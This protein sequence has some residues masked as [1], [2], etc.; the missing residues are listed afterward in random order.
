MKTEMNVHNS[1]HY[2]EAEP[3]SWK[4]WKK[5]RYIVVLLAFLGYFSSYS[6]RV[7][8]SVAI[9]AMTDEDNVSIYSK[10]DRYFDWHPNERGLIFSSFYWAYILTQFLGGILAKKYGGNL[11][12]FSVNALD[13]APDY[14]SVIL[15]FS[16]TFSC[17]TGVISP[18]ITGNLIQN[19]PSDGW[20]IIFY[21][22]GGMYVAGCVIYWFWSSGE[23]QSWSQTEKSTPDDERN[24]V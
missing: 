2:E 1:S 6:L 13:I 3:L 23:L 24:G 11:Y 14:A 10:T 5:R 20:N 19:Q 17:L 22:I 4:F 21:I 18:I 8:L 12:F 7:N 16:N 15:G 9:V